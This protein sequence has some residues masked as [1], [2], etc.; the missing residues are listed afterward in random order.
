M[1]ERTC[2][3]CKH[4]IAMNSNGTT[5]KCKLKTHSPNAMIGCVAFSELTNTEIKDSGNRTG[6][7]TGAVRE[8]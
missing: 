1:S 3:D 4:F 6:V 8:E 2:K 5:C 7:N